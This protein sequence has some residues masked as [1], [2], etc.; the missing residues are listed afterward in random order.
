[1]PTRLPVPDTELV[2]PRC[3]H[4][5]ELVNVGQGGHERTGRRD[6][7]AQA[8]G[9]GH[10]GERRRSTF[11]CKLTS[12]LVIFIAASPAADTDGG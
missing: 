3:S 11:G 7:R 12:T 1:M 10:A 8:G 2:P 5:S 6:P 9:C 4:W